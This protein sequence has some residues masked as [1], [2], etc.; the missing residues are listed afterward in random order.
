M[1]AFVK[2]W[3]DVLY[4]QRIFIITATLIVSVGY[5]AFNFLASYNKLIMSMWL[6]Y[7]AAEKGLN[8]D[9]TRFNVFEIKSVE[10]LD[11]AL[12]KYNTTGITVDELRSRIDV[13]EKSSSTIAEKVK[14]AKISGNE[15]KYIPNEYSISYS[16][17]NKFSKNHTYE[18]L[19]AIAEAYKEVFE[20]KHAENNA[21]LTVGV[22]KL[23]EYEQYE[24]VEIADLLLDNVAAMET[25]ITRRNDE[26]GSYLSETTGE[27]F[28]NVLA[29]IQ[30]FKNIELEKFKAFVVSSAVAKDRETY[31]NKLRYNVENL[32][33]ERSKALREA[34]FVKGAIEKYDPNITGVAFI[35][36]LDENNELYMNRTKTGI[37]YL[38]NTAYNAGINAEKLNKEI[39]KNNYLINMF[40]NIYYDEQ[41]ASRLREKAD[42]MLKELE[43]KLIAIQSIAKKVD[44]EYIA[45]KTRDYIKFNIP[46]KSIINSLDLMSTV[47]FAFW[48][49]LAGCFL[50]LMKERLFRRV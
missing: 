37:D 21:I 14:N 49:F 2:R 36:S 42:N 29:M 22:D 20:A 38:A 23:K 35:P 17:K 48:V 43:E 9:G 10:V 33:F 12:E 46:E 47:I 6:N 7:P 40:S 39:E 3:Y 28:A 34:E 25:Y 31:L 8:P 11:K 18:M 41:E 45:Y 24:Y 4:R 26:S 50:V 16:Q 32:T 5:A 19:S 1:W 30:N 13:Y 15:F 44:D 27:T